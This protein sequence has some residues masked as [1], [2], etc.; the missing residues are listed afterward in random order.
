MARIAKSDSGRYTANPH[1]HVGA[2]VQAPFAVP[3]EYEPRGQP[4]SM[5]TFSRTATGE[6]RRGSS[7]LRRD[8]TRAY[9]QVFEVLYQCTTW[10]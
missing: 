8:L 10:R 2:P 3:V 1:M 7:V 4:G 6:A 9:A 5:R